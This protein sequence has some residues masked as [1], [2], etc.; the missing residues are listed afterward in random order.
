MIKRNLPIAVFDSGYGGLTVLKPLIT[1]LPNTDFIYFGDNNRAPYGSR[2]Q[3]EIIK[4][5]SEIIEWFLSIGIKTVVMACNT[6]TSLALEHNNKNFDINFIN[7]IEHG[8]YGLKS[9]KTAVFATERTIASASIQSALNEKKI[10]NIGIAC[11]E[12]VPL[13]ES[14]MIDSDQL[15]SIASQKIAIAKEFGADSIILGCTHYPIMIDILREIDDS[16]SYID[17]AISTANFLNTAYKQEFRDNKEKGKIHFFTSGDT[18]VFKKKASKL[19]NM[20]I[21]R[22]ER[23]IF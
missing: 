3:D 20:N 8:F 21:D 23:K 16:I 11:P 19:L 10:D 1:A 22:V 18:E 14:D 2:S 15:K 7:L 12:F 5:N 17:P 9:K 13:I 6:S 4:F